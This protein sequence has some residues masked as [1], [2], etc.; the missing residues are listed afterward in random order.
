VLISLRSGRKKA[1][2]KVKKRREVEEHHVGQWALTQR[3]K[4]QMNSWAGPPTGSKAISHRSSRGQQL[5]LGTTL[6]QKT[7]C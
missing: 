1:K 3:D 6:K 2:E 4:W 5:T 7:T